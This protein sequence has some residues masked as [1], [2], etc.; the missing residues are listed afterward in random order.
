A[1]WEHCYDESCEI[2]AI[3]HAYNILIDTTEDAFMA[4]CQNTPI[5]DTGGLEMLT[6][7]QI[8]RKQS[9]FAPET[10]SGD[11]TTLTAFIDVHP[12]ILY[13]AVWAWEPTFTGYCIAYGT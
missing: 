3:Q 6:P 11:C 12:S 4:E 1:T 5:R 10:F 7:E 2:S 8:C 9:G 13:F